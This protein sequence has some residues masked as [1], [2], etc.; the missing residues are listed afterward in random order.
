MVTYEYESIFQKEVLGRETANIDGVAGVDLRKRNPS[1]P[2]PKGIAHKFCGWSVF[3][4]LSLLWELCRIGHK[5]T[6]GFLTHLDLCT[7]EVELTTSP[8][9]LGVKKSPRLNLQGSSWEV[10][11]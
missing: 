1:L 5:S 3:P 2:L 7:G 11:T 4:A 10:W 8:A 6:S 9:D